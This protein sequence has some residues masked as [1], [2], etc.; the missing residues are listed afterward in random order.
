M[1]EELENFKKHP[2]YKYA[3][4]VTNKKFPA[5][6]LITKVCSDFLDELE[7]PDSEFFFDYNLVEGIDG[8]LGMIIVPSGFKAGHPAR[9]VLAG[10]QWF[11][12]LNALCWKMKNDH[13]KRRYEKSILLIARK[14]GKT[15]IT[16][17]LFIIL[18]LLEPPYSNFFSVAPTLELSKLIFTEVTNQLNNSPILAKNFRITN[19]Y[20]LCLR[21]HNK[22]T[23]LATGKQTMDGRL[24][25]VFVVDEVGA[26]RD[27]YP[28]SAMES[29]QMNI[30]N[31]TGILISTAYPTLSNPMT[32]Q[33]EMVEKSILGKKVHKEIFGMI[34]KPD[35]PSEWKTSDAELLKANPLA[36]ESQDSLTLLKKKREDAI[37]MEGERGNFLTKHMNIFINGAIND[38][39]VTSEEM[40]GIEI[41]SGTIDWEGREVYLGLDLSRS[42]DNTAVAM[43]SF[44]KDTEVLLAKT[45]IFYPAGR[46][47]EKLKAEGLDYAKATE[48]GLSIPSG[49]MVIDYDQIENFI[50][51]VERNYGVIVKGIGYDPWSAPALAVRLSK[52]YEVYKVGQGDSGA[53]VPARFLKE[54]ILAKTF[55]YEEN[56]LLTSNFLNAKKKISDTMSYHLNKKASEGKIDAVAAIVDSVALWLN[57]INEDAEGESFV[58]II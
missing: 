46:E 9:E 34:Y 48:L 27:S 44:D 58:G 21:N 53:Y 26:L 36:I 54:K 8:I 28:I 55:H 25:N 57:E 23:P 14:S 12:I 22:F 4:D 37:E 39:Y 35:F 10:F 29:S 3:Y 42:E 1:S 2:A 43:T 32:E 52:E 41:P 45:W 24:A 56:F 18:L 15:F 30:K 11:F 31:R 16:A 19:N 50:F 6:E 13:E 40:Q 5:N 17:L 38:T 7:N 47:A 51:D 20:I 33:V 49:D